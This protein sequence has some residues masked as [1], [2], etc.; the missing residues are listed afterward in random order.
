MLHYIY[1][2][3]L[4]ENFLIPEQTYFLLWVAFTYFVCGAGDYVAAFQLNL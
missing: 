4:I 2:I 1:Q 3:L